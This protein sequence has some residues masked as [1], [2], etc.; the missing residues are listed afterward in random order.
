MLVI[1][2]VG[3]LG[4]H[5]RNM[6][7]LDQT[8]DLHTVTDKS[9]V[10]FMLDDVYTDMRSWHNWLQIEYQYSARLNPLIPVQHPDYTDTQWRVQPTVFTTLDPATCYHHYLKF[11][12]NLNALTKR[13]F[14]ELTQ[15]HMDHWIH[16]AGTHHNVTALSVESLF[17]GE[18]DASWLDRLNTAFG[19]HIDLEMART[20]H[21]K[22]QKLNRRAEQQLVRHMIKEY[23]N[24]IDTSN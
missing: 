23:P 19:L 6:C 22:W 15:Q 13:Y 1:A 2:C 8:I 24:A 21:A 5:V 18:L 16:T 17:D 3:G 10:D 7:L 4:N 12:S 14:I 20:V 11:N 9:A